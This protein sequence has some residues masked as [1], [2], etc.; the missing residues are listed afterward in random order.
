MNTIIKKS[1]QGLLIVPALA[2]AT[3]VVTPVLQPSTAVAQTRSGAAAGKATASTGTCD[4]EGGLSSGVACAKSDEQ[5]SEL[6]GSGSIFETVVNV[7]LFIVGAIAV[8]MLIYGGFKYVISGGDAGAVTSAKNTILYAVVGIIV[9]LLAYAIIN[10]VVG[11]FA[12]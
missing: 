6:F 2:L 10:F 4:P 3:S 9:A 8:I 7:L 11:K 5:Q 12:V 1:L